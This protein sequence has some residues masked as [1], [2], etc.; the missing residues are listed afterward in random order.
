MSETNIPIESPDNESPDF[1]PA[2]VAST[3]YQDL[4]AALAKRIHFHF[5]PTGMP[6]DFIQ[7]FIPV[8]TCAIE[9]ALQ[10]FAA[11]QLEH[12]GDIRTRDLERDETQ[13]IYDLFL[14]RLCKATQRK[15]MLTYVD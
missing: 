14:Y 3:D 4:Q 7:A 12:G 2:A 13:E 6:A 10:K 5:D 9:S 15:V 1:I 11:G 8:F